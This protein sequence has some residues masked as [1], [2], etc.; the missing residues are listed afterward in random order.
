MQKSG[1]KRPTVYKILGT[2]IEKGLAEQDESGPI[3][4]FSSKHPYAIKE[5]IDN[6]IRSIKSADN[7]LDAALPGLIS[8]YNAKSSKPGVRYLEGTEG[9]K[10]IYED[11]LDT[12]QDVLIF[13]SPQDTTNPEI[14]AIIDTNIKKQKKLGIKTRAFVNPEFIDSQKTLSQLL[15]NNIEPHVV[16]NQAL[17]LPSQILIYGDKVAIVSLKGEIISTLIDNK[18][19][20]QSLKMIFEYTWKLSQA[21]H[22]DFCAS[23]PDKPAR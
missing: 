16:P 15:E 21:A 20:G 10:K 11:I 3:I 17:A 14:D 7:E 18:N 1:L 12:K 8:T 13:T 2:L 6:K 22:H 9:F 4:Q 19:I 23:L 5:F